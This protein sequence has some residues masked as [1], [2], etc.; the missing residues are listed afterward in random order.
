MLSLGSML[1]DIEAIRRQHVVSN[2]VIIRTL[3][4]H[5]TSIVLKVQ[6]I[7]ANV[8]SDKAIS[9]LLSISTEPLGE[10]SHRNT[11]VAVTG[12]GVA[13]S[14]G[15][16]KVGTV[17]LVV[18]HAVVVTVD[19]HTVVL[20]DNVHQRR[21]LGV[22]GR[23][24]DEAVVDLEDL[25]GSIGLGEGIAQELDLLLGGLV[26][27]NDVVGVVDR[28][29]LLVLVDEAV[30]VDDGK[31]RGP[32]GALQVVGIVGQVVVA[33]VPPVL[34]QRGD[35][36]LEVDTGLAG[37]DVVVAQGLVPG[38]AVEG[39]ADVHVGPAFVE[40]LDS[41][42]GEVDTAVVEVV[43]DGHE[44][45]AVLLEADLFDVLGGASCAGC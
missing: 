42:G 41:L 34:H 7:V 18:G 20:A 33:K 31:G 10:G 24:G 16:N 38:L 35:A 11:V 9:G 21:Q 23:R 37:H 39:F 32:V 1:S 12:L 5:I 30:R 6:R 43:A 22:V 36:G 8:K 19:D 4:L 45:R 15:E 29:A 14:T 17:E 44:G 13:G 28:G 3:E 26:A 40:T 27:F 2:G 25:P